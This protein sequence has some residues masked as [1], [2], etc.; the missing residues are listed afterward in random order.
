MSIISDILHTLLGLEKDL[1]RA[2]SRLNALEKDRS[3]LRDFDSEN[4]NILRRFFD[5]AVKH[6]EEVIK[7]LPDP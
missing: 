1:D 2:E 3:S 6:Q 4:R 7:N 5:K